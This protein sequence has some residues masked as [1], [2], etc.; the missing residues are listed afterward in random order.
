MKTSL[1]KT[2]LCV[3]VIT[4]VLCPNVGAKES[5]DPKAITLEKVVHF[6][7]PDGSDVLIQPGA[8]RVEAAD[9]GIHLI[10]TEGKARLIGAEVGTHDEEVETPLSVSLTGEEE[11]F[12]DLFLVILLFPGGQSLEAAGSYSGVRERGLRVKKIRNFKLRA[13]PKITQAAKEL[14]IGPALK[15]IGP[16][17]LIG[18][19]IYD[20]AV[21]QI[22]KV[23]K[24]SGKWYW[25]GHYDLNPKL[26]HLTWGILPTLAAN[27]P[28]IISKEGYGFELR[29]NGNL[30]QQGPNALSGDFYAYPITNAGDPFACPHGTTC[31]GTTILKN[32]W[33]S[34]TPPWI[35]ELSYWKK[36]K[37]S[38]AGGK[39]PPQVQKAIGLVYPNQ[40]TGKS[41]FT[42]LI[43]PIF[44]H[45]R[46]KSCHAL[47]SKTE[48]VQRHNGILSEGQIGEVQGLLGMN[49]G[50]GGGCHTMIKEA[51][52]P[53]PNVVFHDSEWKT[54]RFD[55]GIDWRGKS[56]DYI[57]QKVT[58]SLTTSQKLRD[59]FFHDARIAWAVHSGLIPP[60]VGGRLT[61]APPGNYFQFKKR[62]DAWIRAGVPCP[63]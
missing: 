33:V 5:N 11:E 52:Q 57:C 8:Y 1:T 54:P 7:A 46:C 17:G 56:D 53:V 2:L 48:L 44:Q 6:L 31:L 63:K 16:V 55:M 4:G 27:I 29:L 49:L 43:Y 62:M 23:Q 12:K 39:E 59:H 34:V 24:T 22:R 14:R 28:E 32:K 25:P 26:I 19:W 50:C 51:T 37:I 20:P 9:N 60:P 38:E 15:Y 61:K 41:Y 36:V 18:L 42:H 13:K 21:P 30:L 58:S 35:L 40:T 10:P 47:G 45:D 3:L